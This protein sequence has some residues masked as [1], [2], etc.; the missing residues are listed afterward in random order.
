MA[1]DER[2]L[3]AHQRNEQMELIG[4]GT[5]SELVE[6]ACGW[7][8]LGGRIGA[9]FESALRFGQIA[10]ERAGAS[11]AERGRKARPVD[12][13]DGDG[14]LVVQEGLRERRHGQRGGHPRHTA[15]L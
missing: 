10:Q 2:C 7:A 14:G 8:V 15:L 6:K 5:A 12:I 1:E 11:G 13:G 3:V 9:G 4:F